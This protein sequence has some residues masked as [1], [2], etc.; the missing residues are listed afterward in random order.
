MKERIELLLGCALLLRWFV[1]CAE[2][3]CGINYFEE[4]DTVI[5]AGQHLSKT[6][7]IDGVPD[8]LENFCFASVWVTSDAAADIFPHTSLKGSQISI[9]F[10]ATLAGKYSIHVEPLECGQIFQQIASNLDVVFGLGSWSRTHKIEFIADNFTVANMFVSWNGWINYQSTSRFIEISANSRSGKSWV[11]LDGIMVIDCVKN[12]CLDPSKQRISYPGIFGKSTRVQVGFYVDSVNFDLA[13]FNLSWNSLDSEGGNFNSSSIC[14][15]SKEVGKKVW[16]VYVQS[17]TAS[18]ATSYVQAL[19][20]TIGWAGSQIVVRYQMRDAYSNAVE[21]D[22]TENYVVAWL[23]YTGSSG[24][25]GPKTIQAGGKMST[26]IVPAN[27]GVATC[28]VCLI[29]SLGLHATYY[30]HKAPTIC[31]AA[32]IQAS[33]DFS[34][35][36]NQV[37]PSVSCPFSARWQGFVIASASSVHTFIISTLEASNSQIQIVVDG[38]LHL[39]SWS[40]FPSVSSVSGTFKMVQN[41]IYSVQIHYECFSSS[42]STDFHVKLEWAYL[43]FPNEVI[44]SSNLIP[45]WDFNNAGSKSNGFQVSVQSK[46][47]CTTLST[48]Y[49]SGLTI[50]T[51]GSKVQFSLI[52]YDEYGQIPSN[53]IE[54]VLGTVRR[55]ESGW[56]CHLNVVQLTFNSWTFSWIPTISGQYTVAITADS[57]TLCGSNSASFNVQSGPISTTASSATV[58]SSTIYAGERAEFQILTRDAYGNKAVI[59]D[60]SNLMNIG[61]LVFQNGNADSTCASSTLVSEF[62]PSQVLLKSTLMSAA[63]MYR[64]D[65]VIMSSIIESFGIRVLPSQQLAITPIGSVPTKGVIGETST[66]YYSCCLDTF[67]N[68]ASEALIFASAIGPTTVY[69]NIIQPNCQKMT[70]AQASFT[71]NTV[72]TYS[73]FTKYS[74]GTGF[75]ATYY[76]SVSHVS[77]IV[78]KTC[79]IP[80]VLRVAGDRE[81]PLTQLDTEDGYSVRWKGFMRKY[82]AGVFTIAIQV[83][84]GDT[85][86]VVLFVDGIQ[87]FNNI[88][89][90]AKTNMYSATLNF[91]DSTS[92]H[93]ILLEYVRGAKIGGASHSSFLAF[94]FLDSSGTFVGIQSIDNHD[95][96]Y[97][98]DLIALGV[99]QSIVISSNENTPSGLSNVGTNPVSLWNVTASRAIDFQITPKDSFNSALTKCPNSVVIM[100]QNGFLEFVPTKQ[101]TDQSIIKCNG[102][103][104]SSTTSGIFQ[105]QIFATN[106]YAGATYYQDASFNIPVKTSILSILSLKWEDVPDPNAPGPIPFKMAWMTQVNSSCIIIIRCSTL[107]SVSLNMQSLFPSSRSDLGK[108]VQ[109]GQYRSW[110]PFFEENRTVYFE[111]FGLIQPEDTAFVQKL[112]NRRNIYSWGPM[113]HLVLVSKLTMFVTADV[114]LASN[115]KVSAV[116]DVL[117]IFVPVNV[118]I[119]KIACQRDQ[120]GNMQTIRSLIIGTHF[121]KISSLGTEFGD[122]ISTRLQSFSENVWTLA[123]EGKKS[124]LYGSLCGVLGVGSLAATFYDTE[125]KQYKQGALKASIWSR[126]L[127]SSFNLDSAPASLVMSFGGFVAFQNSVARTLKVS[128]DDTG[129]AALSLWID[130][131]LKMNTTVPAGSSATVAF[132]GTNFSRETTIAGEILI[133]IQLIC[134]TTHQDTKLTLLWNE[135]GNFVQIPTTNMY[136]IIHKLQ[137]PNL[138][139]SFEAKSYDQDA[140]ISCSA[141]GTGLSI[142]TVGFLASFS[143]FCKDSMGYAL[144]SSVF[145]S[146]IRCSLLNLE[147][148]VQVFY[149]SPCMM[150][151]KDSAVHIS[152]LPSSMK[153][154]IMLSVFED[155]GFW[156]TYYS[157]TNWT[158]PVA[159]RTE[160]AIDFSHFAAA[161]PIAALNAGYSVRWRGF[162][163]MPSTGPLTMLFSKNA[164]NYTLMTDGRALLNSQ[165]TA[166][167]M[168]LL[169]SLNTDSNSINNM[170]KL[171]WVGFSTETSK[172]SSSLKFVLEDSQQMNIVPGLC[173][174]KTSFITGSAIATIGTRQSLSLTLRDTFENACSLSTFAIAAYAMGQIF[175]APLFEKM[176]KLNIAW[177]KA[178]LYKV[179][180]VMGKSRSGPEMTLF[181]DTAC[182][183]QLNKRSLQSVDF[184]PTNLDI[185]ARCLIV[186]GLIELS[187]ATSYSV[188]AQIDAAYPRTGA[189]LPCSINLTVWGVGTNVSQDDASTPFVVSTIS[190]ITDMPGFVHFSLT[191]IHAQNC[192]RIKL[193]LSSFID[194]YRSIDIDSSNSG[195]LLE[196]AMNAMRIK[197]ISNLEAS[198]IKIE[199]LSSTQESDQF[200]GNSLIESFTYSCRAE[201]DVGTLC[202]T[203]EVYATTCPKKKGRRCS[204]PATG[205]NVDASQTAAFKSIITVA[206]A[207]KQSLAITAGFGLWATYYE[208]AFLYSPFVSFVEPSPAAS[209]IK[210]DSNSFFVPKSGAM[211]AKWSGFI[212]TNSDLVTTIT[213]QLV[214][215]NDS[216]MVW[217]DNSLVIDQRFT[218]GSQSSTISLLTNTMFD[219]EVEY[220][221]FGIGDAQMDITIS[222]ITLYFAFQNDVITHSLNLNAARSAIC[223]LV[224]T[225]A[226]L[227]IVTFGVPVS[228]SLSCED[229]FYN[230]INFGKSGISLF[231]NSEDIPVSNPIY[232]Q[233]STVVNELIVISSVISCCVS[234][235]SFKISVDEA[236]FISPT[237]ETRSLPLSESNTLIK[238][239]TIFTAGSATVFTV[240]LRD[241]FNGSIMCGN[242]YLSHMSVSFANFSRLDR[243]RYSIG[244]TNCSVSDSQLLSLTSFV[245]HVPLL[246]HHQI[247]KIGYLVRIFSS[248]QPTKASLIYE[249]SLSSIKDLN[250]NS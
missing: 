74:V 250:V 168:E 35:G 23:Q 196:S 106:H 10:T 97:S 125:K 2:A 154:K 243:S 39:N 139:Q 12:R 83:E 178:D 49:G 75:V 110:R 26:V 192:N 65:I 123:F 225:T 5:R 157:F 169:Y 34:R 6:F 24:Q 248:D 108:S 232:S 132:M 214:S 40:V 95:F 19:S 124:G 186:E 66:F 77:A 190:F 145:A 59:P 234:K 223:H 158:S 37:S 228:F 187:A 42:A 150:K 159:S 38:W 119:M 151:S 94:G 101:I 224:T 239:P 47:V 247:C 99:M 76:S 179:N 52:I 14:V 238:G 61:L 105:L 89:D 195:M 82:I 100:R 136:S 172:V 127:L 27:V 18:A 120:F 7:D 88:A 220:K 177:E 36:T 53:I 215:Q 113:Q 193:T 199:P 149:S 233:T 44:P 165:A 13:Y 80:S 4:S 141:L 137:T 202:R 231:V 221:H 131:T 235:F 204:Q 242:S 181:Q 85:E 109:I 227:T 128:V 11:S 138:L 16:T 140:N 216:L 147:P 41:N 184:D 249:F 3:A 8:E 203:D 107:I 173:C 148:S 143:V 50:A 209:T 102:T 206:S 114:T 98:N 122:G 64:I 15:S 87:I 163:F 33:I 146:Q 152:L 198:R 240:Y 236:T 142:M 189:E 73:I 43:N 91:V 79:S 71:F 86:K 171:E 96:R 218:S 84:N 31:I 210:L 246:I 160:L 115:C 46:T 191:Y 28:R 111:F 103:I 104:F 176:S 69:P 130:G 245:P 126:S 54:S 72:G 93:E 164:G 185:N 229:Q 205:L 22:S 90:F 208:D 174:L 1:P 170:V 67:G 32:A 188:R 116:G 237:F 194:S 57:K 117:N 166:V 20:T 45:S 60:C 212:R 222:T 112:C 219:I 92:Y 213:S 155:Q 21:V 217:I 241:V 51:S 29:G 78:S 180:L 25:D 129:R 133:P 197:V 153:H 121:N 226:L 244:S 207:Y 56:T 144:D 30:S 48:C 118:V 9:H 135:D 161:A 200:A 230:S 156:A 183:L 17:S 134:T 81:Y 62:D 175:Q 182:S 201:N 70:L 55:N 68:L 167:P 58:F 63:A 162:C 211:S